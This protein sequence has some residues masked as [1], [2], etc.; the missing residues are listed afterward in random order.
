MT[1]PLICSPVEEGLQ[2]LPMHSLTHATGKVLLL[3]PYTQ[4]S[5]IIVPTAPGNCAGVLLNKE[6]YLFIDPFKF[7]RCFRTHL[8]NDD[9]LIAQGLYLMQIPTDTE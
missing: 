2:V 7:S 8:R 9:A 3:L 5:G 1:S 4:N 6:Q